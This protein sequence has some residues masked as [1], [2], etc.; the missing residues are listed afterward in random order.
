MERLIPKNREDGEPFPEREAMFIL[1]TGMI[2]VVIY[3]IFLI[4]EFI[5]LI[6]EL[7]KQNDELYI[8]YFLRFVFFGI[9]IL[10]QVLYVILVIN[11]LLNMEKADNEE[12]AQN[13]ILLTYAKLFTSLF[14]VWTIFFLATGIPRLFIF[15]NNRE[16]IGKFIAALIYI[17]IF[18]LFPIYVIFIL[19]YVVTRKNKKK[20]G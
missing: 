20:D 5:D 18:L 1:K 2:C 11:F 15:F 3:F 7:V 12:D 4:F 16:K 17:K 14:T 9:S 13:K 6:T 19:T 10:I 8:F